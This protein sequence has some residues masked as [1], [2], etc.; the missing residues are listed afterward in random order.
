MDGSVGLL[1]GFGAGVSILPTSILHDAEQIDQTVDARAVLALAFAYAWVWSAVSIKNWRDVWILTGVAAFLRD[2]Y[3]R[4]VHGTH[5]QLESVYRLR[6]WIRQHDYDMVPLAS[7]RFI[8]PLET[9][10]EVGLAKAS[11]VFYMLER[12]AG[13][14]SFQKVVHALLNREESKKEHVRTTSLI[15]MFKKQVGNE[16]KGQSIKTFFELWVHGGG[17]PTFRVGFTFNRETFLIDLAVE[18]HSSLWSPNIEKLEEDPSLKIRVHEEA[19]VYDHALVIPAKVPNALVKAPNKNIPLAHVPC[20]SKKKSMRK[21]RMEKAG[22]IQPR[23]DG[24]AY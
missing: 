4:A 22:L 5:K 15:K 14:E 21:Q 11:L 6:S 17:S 7:E 3:L 10:H 8:H 19:G 24:N 13:T 16:T 1:P 23:V 18:Q 9:L 12:R 2:T 20:H